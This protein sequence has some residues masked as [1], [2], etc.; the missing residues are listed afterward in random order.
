MFK[1]YLKIAFR[2]LRRNRLYATISIAGLSIGL[3]V[4]FVIAAYVAHEP[5]EG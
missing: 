3:S 1:S 2:N 4:V 5:R